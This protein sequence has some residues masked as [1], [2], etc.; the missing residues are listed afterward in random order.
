MRNLTGLGRAL[1]GMGEYDVAEQSF[2]RA[3]EHDPGSEG[4]MSLLGSTLYKLGCNEEALQTLNEVIAIFPDSG[5]HYR[6][7]AFV[8]LEMNRREEAHA[9]FIREIESRGAEIVTYWQNYLIEKKRLPGPADGVD[10]PVFREAFQ[11]CVLD[12]TC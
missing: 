1:Y 3:L 10:S 2:R 6:N 4:T 7:R 8:L 5:D 12:P 9:D 11:A